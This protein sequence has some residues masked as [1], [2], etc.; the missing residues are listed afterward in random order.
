[1]D[2]RK[3]SAA[4]DQE[5]TPP[6][7]KPYQKPAFVRERAF[8]TMALSCGKINTTQAQCKLNRKSS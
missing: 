4:R 2:E 8:E 3:D 7:K 1:M 5:P 6:V